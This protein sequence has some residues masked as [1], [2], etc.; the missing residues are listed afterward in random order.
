M[1]YGVKKEYYW[2]GIEK[3]SFYNYEVDEYDITL[4]RGFETEEL[5]VA[6]LEEIVRKYP[7]VENEYDLGIRYVVQYSDQQE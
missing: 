1:G 6:A 3:Y 2:K 4:F 5:A 7:Y